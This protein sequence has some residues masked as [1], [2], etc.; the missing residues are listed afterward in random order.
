MAGGIQS[1]VAP[2]F[3][4]VSRRHLWQDGRLTN[5]ACWRGACSPKYRCDEARRTK[6]H[7]LCLFPSCSAAAVCNTLLEMQCWEA[8]ACA[9]Q[10]AFQAQRSLTAW[11][12]ICRLWHPRK[13]CGLSFYTRSLILVVGSAGNC[14]DLLSRGTARRCC[15]FGACTPPCSIAVLRAAPCPYEQG[16]QRRL[17]CG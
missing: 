1:H 7:D 13:T 6:P 17:S 15:S 5:G 14:V 10:F 12:H 3:A 11:G 4:C 8:L 2:S 16:V 9:K